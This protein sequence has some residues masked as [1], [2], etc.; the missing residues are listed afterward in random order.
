[1]LTM[2]TK[3]V[4]VKRNPNTLSFVSVEDTF[5]R[6]PCS[7]TAVEMMTIIAKE[8]H[9]RKYLYSENILSAIFCAVRPLLAL[10][11]TGHREIFHERY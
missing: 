3:C 9:A 1:M 2:C 5:L 7:D 6:T 10:C 11:V 4:L 8:G